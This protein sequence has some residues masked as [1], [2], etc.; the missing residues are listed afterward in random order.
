LAPLVRHEN[1][2]YLQQ[3]QLEHKVATAAFLCG[4]CLR[5]FQ[6][7][8]RHP[9]GVLPLPVSAPDQHVAQTPVCPAESTA[10]ATCQLCESQRIVSESCLVFRTVMLY[11]CVVW[12]EGKS[13][14]LSGGWSARVR[15]V[16]GGRCRPL[17]AVFTGKETRDEEGRFRCT[18]VVFLV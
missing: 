18:S 11:N 1:R 10:P 16:R 5:S 6:P 17:S 2:K 12:S 7:S 8:T 15:Y 9:L 3:K 4:N 13:G 14:S